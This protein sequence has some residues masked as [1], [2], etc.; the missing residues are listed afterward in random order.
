MGGWEGCG[1][2]G[3]ERNYNLTQLC[4]CTLSLPEVGR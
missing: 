1:G 2:V 4:I 3:E